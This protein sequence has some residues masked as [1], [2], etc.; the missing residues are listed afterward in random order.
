M[1]SKRFVVSNT[2]DITEGGDS[3][4]GTLRK[5]IQDINAFYRQANRS[6]IAVFLDFE[7]KN[8]DFKGW[9]FKPEIPLPPILKGNVY[10]NHNDPKFVIL[11]GEKLSGDRPSLIPAWVKEPSGNKQNQ[12]SSLM[13]LGDSSYINT[14]NP[15]D[16]IKKSIFRFKSVN[17]SGNHAAGEN[18]IVNGGG[19][20]GAGGGISLVSGHAVMEDAVF[21]DLKAIGGTGGTTKV[22]GGE[23][24]DEKLK[25]FLGG[26]WDDGGAG[27]AG[28]R[29]GRRGSFTIDTQ[30]SYS[31]CNGG[32]GGHR[33][34]AKNGWEFAKTLQKAD[35]DNNNDYQSQLETN[36]QQG[37]AGGNGGN[38]INCSSNFGNGGGGGGA[39][40]AGSTV[41]GRHTFWKGLQPFFEWEVLGWGLGGDGGDGGRGGFGAGGGGGGGGSWYG[42][43]YYFR[44]LDESKIGKYGESGQGGNGGSFGTSGQRGGETDVEQVKGDGQNTFD[45]TRISGFDEGGVGGHGAALGGSISVLSPHSTI[46]LL[47]VDFINSASEAQDGAGRF[48]IIYSR[49]GKKG[50]IKGSSINIYESYLDENGKRFTEYDKILKDNRFHTFIEKKENDEPAF[51]FNAVSSPRVDELAKIRNKVI[52]LTPGFPESTIIRYDRPESGIISINVD[53]SSLI[54][55]LNNIHEQ[56]IPTEDKDTIEARLQGKLVSS[57]IQLGES[58]TGLEIPTDLFSAA[59]TAFN[60][61]GKDSPPSKIGDAAK[62]IATFGFSIVNARKEF[63]EEVEENNRKINLLAKKTDSNRKLLEIPDIDIERS[64]TLI[65]I[66]NFTIGEDIIYLQD[67]GRSDSGINGPIITAGSTNINSSGEQIESFDI[68]LSN[69]RNTSDQTRIATVSLDNTSIS[70]LNSAIQRDPAAYIRS[71]LYYDFKKNHWVLGKTLTNKHRTSQSSGTDYF[72]GPA[73]ELVSLERTG[74]VQNQEV[75][76][77]AT[78]SFD[79]LIYGSIGNEKIFT[80]FGEDQIF[81]GLGRDVVNGGDGFDLVNYQSIGIPIKVIGDK[82]NDINVKASDQ[83]NVLQITPIDETADITLE[84]ILLN[85]EAITA[86]G[87]SKI[88]LRNLRKADDIT[89]INMNDSVKGYHAIRSGLGS[90]IHGSEYDDTIIISMLD[91]RDENPENYMRAFECTNGAVGLAKPTIVTSGGG[92]DQLIFMTEPVDNVD[93][94]IQ[95]GTVD[96]P[97]KTLEGYNFIN[98]LG[99]IVAFVKG[100]DKEDIVQYQ[101]LSSG[102]VIQKPVAIANDAV[103]PVDYCSHAGLSA[104]ETIENDQGEPKILP[105]EYSIDE[106]GFYSAKKIKEDE[107]LTTPDPSTELAIRYNGTPEK[108]RLT[109]KLKSDQLIGGS[110]NDILTGA[111][112]IS[113]MGSMEFYDYNFFNDGDG[114][115]V[116]NI[117][118]GY[119]IALIGAGKNK[120][121][122][123]RTNLPGVPETET[124]NTLIFT[125]GKDKVFNYSSVRDQL[126]FDNIKK[127][128]ISPTQNKKQAIKDG[129]NVIIGKNTIFHRG[130]KES[131]FSKVK[132]KKPILFDP[133]QDKLNLLPRKYSRQNDRFTY[134]EL[135]LPG[136][137][138]LCSE[139]DDSQG[140][141]LT[142]FG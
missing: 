59:S 89:N 137:N 22:M 45:F 2:K 24:V 121:K 65:N 92:N 36:H 18:G 43:H 140:L 21:Q 128:K 130:D 138:C 70:G 96:D 108:D 98:M 114:N 97:S 50:Q 105:F 74:G 106:D 129:F 55:E 31:I 134:N 83:A 38:G 13:T 28:N 103:I 25:T 37:L 71:L 20:L 44:K 3:G 73:S 116:I 1:E 54:K 57:A 53:S 4:S 34:N 72:G 16:D 14:T 26:Q 9:I 124:F 51:L 84:S 10:I 139:L 127:L 58:I 46:E 82:A 49:T 142:L 78:Q 136:D 100:F 99:R 67:F 61:L 102:E 40:G 69:T 113:D 90:T 122:L 117:K 104:K 111:F 133:D 27:Q 110:G 77:I 76:K 6:N 112:P 118:G 5:A 17:F 32:A 41:R 33:A 68:H 131:K 47:N 115:D 107:N 87:P 15:P 109:A 52:D 141:L 64:R 29:G 91:S 11:N 63:K 19:G 88:D 81:P 119:N 48:D 56:L 12:N 80:S 95:F 126:I 132:F 120:I 125:N 62:A 79:D 101:K 86:F 35:P 30:S 60:F 93:L 123:P 85:V 94:D 135:V 8:D 42:G 66:E 23:S 75:I 7:T 39:G